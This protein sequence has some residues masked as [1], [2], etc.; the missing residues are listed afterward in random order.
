[1]SFRQLHSVTPPK[2]LGYYGYNGN[3]GPLVVNRP[4][5]IPFILPSSG[6]PISFNFMLG[7]GGAG[8]MDVGVFDSTFSRVWN[9]G[10]FAIPA[11]GS[12]VAK[13]WTQGPLP[14]GQYWLGVVADFAIQPKGYNSGS[15]IKG[16]GITS[17]SNCGV[18]FPAGIL[19]GA[20]GD[21]PI[22]INSYLRMT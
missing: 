2:I 16:Q 8:N 4:Y 17:G 13:A 3:V 5:L 6:L 18:P 22:C 15:V 20:L 14:A 12:F 7:V 19:P 21:T 1:M 11:A 9:N 10:S